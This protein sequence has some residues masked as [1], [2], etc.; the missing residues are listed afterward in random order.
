MQ[1]II[2]KLL[3]NVPRKLPVGMTQFETFANRVISIA[4]RFADED[5]LKF[6]LAT[7]II[8]ADAAKGN[9]PDSFFVQRLRKAAA[10]QVASQVFQ[11]IKVKQVAQQQAA[12]EKQQAE[13]AA[14]ETVTTDGTQN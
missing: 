14:A 8:H 10:N 12:L 6:A 11:D 13:A 1:T 4:G 7:A 3:Q 9:I 5:S 2:A